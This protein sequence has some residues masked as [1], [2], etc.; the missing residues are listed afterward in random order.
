MS[1]LQKLFLVY[2]NLFL[3]IYSFFWL[4]ILIN[5]WLI[6]ESYIILGCIILF[7]ALWLFFVFDL[8]LIINCLAISTNFL[9]LC[10]GLSLLLLGLLCTLGCRTSWWLSFCGCSL[11]LVT[12]DIWCTTK[13]KR[14]VNQPI[15]HSNTQT[16]HLKLIKRW[17]HILEQRWNSC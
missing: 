17:S 6:L 11:Q 5:L 1:F 8:S 4:L 14:H 16:D 3:F 2:F 13:I 9:F 7:T 12:I 15:N 10:F